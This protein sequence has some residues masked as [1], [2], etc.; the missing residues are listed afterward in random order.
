MKT[1]GVVASLA[2]L[3]AC[4]NSLSTGTIRTMEVLVGGTAVDLYRAYN[5]ETHESE[6]L[7]GEQQSVSFD[8]ELINQ[9]SE[10]VTV[11]GI[12]WAPDTVAGGLLKNPNVEIVW[13]NNVSFP[14]EIGIGDEY[15]FEV[16]YTPPAQAADTDARDSILIIASNTRDRD[17]TNPVPEI[18]LTFEVPR[19]RGV[20]LVSPPNYTF[21]TATP[22]SPGEHT[23]VVTN[24]CETGTASF[25]VT[26]IELELFTNEFKIIDVQPFLPFT[27]VP[28]A[29]E[30][31]DPGVL[32]FTLRYTPTGVGDDVNAVLVSV[33]GEG[34]PLR[35]PVSSDT[36]LGSWSLDYKDKTN[37][38]DFSMSTTIETR[39][40]LLQ[41]NGPGV[42]KV[43]EPWVEDEA[44]AAIFSWAAFTPA[45]SPDAEDTLITSWPRALAEGKTIRFD[46][47]YT[48]PVDPAVKPSNGQMHIE[49]GIPDPDLAVIDLFAGEPKGKLVVAPS[50][51]SV[52]VTAAAADIGRA[53]DDSEASADILPCAK[54][55]LCVNGVCE[56]DSGTR[57]VVLYNEGN[58]TLTI[59]QLVMSGPFS[60][61]A[62]NFE[63]VDA[64]AQPF[65]I[66]PNDMVVL[67]LDWSTAQLADLTGGDTDELEV[68]YFDPYTETTVE[69]SITLMLQDN[70]GVGQPIAEI[71]APG[72]EEE[73]LVDA[74]VFLSGAE[75]YD[76]G[77]TYELFDYSYIWYLVSKP[78]GSATKLNEKDG[79][80]QTL[81]PDRPGDYIVELAV[82]AFDG[83]DFLVSPPTQAV[84]TATAETVD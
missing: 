60:A 40:V 80:L 54:P 45:T 83:S 22:T 42:L 61:P 53:C 24:D 4:G 18:S 5:G 29:C 41:S 68:H 15:V 56:A 59:E 8:V 50:T 31:G 74:P 64:P 3:V 75:S 28:G 79:V 35:V 65:E 39:E 44:A 11:T 55:E 58:G 57:H 32:E 7:L 27:V 72:P 82:I 48:P 12:D 38:M 13:P 20:A 21:E 26:G 17:G 63:L 37:K 71:T 81:K 10:S 66:A 19:E 70:R 46:V 16:K 9:G 51:M 67:K 69:R 78:A 25:E 36:V 23:F 33:S 30:P 84:I 52:Q 43:K 77:S 76:G 47:T 2:L 6:F 62:K 14:I 49:V 34:L 73:V 1:F